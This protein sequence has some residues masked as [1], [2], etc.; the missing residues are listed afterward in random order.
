M[1]WTRNPPTFA[2]HGTGIF[3]SLQAGEWQLLA[4]DKL[5]NFADKNCSHRVK[6]YSINKSR[7]LTAARLK[8]L[9]E[10]GVPIVPITHPMEFDLQSEED[11]MEEMKK[12]GG[13]D[14]LE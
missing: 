4:I 3:T 8:L 1:P 10:K 13:R 14:P 2:R 11:Y 7:P 5:E 9:E 12:Q 6:I